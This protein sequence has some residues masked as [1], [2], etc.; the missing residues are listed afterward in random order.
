MVNSHPIFVGIPK[1]MLATYLQVS[2]L[3]LCLP[4]GLGMVG[5]TM[6]QLG[7]QGF[8]KCFPK[9]GYK[10]RSTIQHYGLLNPMQTKNT[11]NI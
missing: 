4:T 1:H 7:T 8:M 2:D 3:P 9:L 5:Q 10:L 6:K 11:S